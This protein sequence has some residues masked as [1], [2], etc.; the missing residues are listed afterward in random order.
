MESQP[1]YNF[2]M[3]GTIYKNGHMMH[4]LDGPAVIPDNGKPK[5]F[6]NNYPASN[7][8]ERFAKE[9]FIDLENLTEEDKTLIAIK[10]ANFPN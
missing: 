9:M 2:V 6:V 1:Y 3:Q 7:E 4:R 8:V 10:F 5:W